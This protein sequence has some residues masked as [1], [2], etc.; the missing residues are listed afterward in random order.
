MIR[1][2]LIFLIGFNLIACSS[3]S[4]TKENDIKS[5]LHGVWAEYYTPEGEIISYVTYIP[6]GRFHGFGYYDENKTEYWFAHGLWEMRGNQSCI[7]FQFD[8]YGMMDPNEEFC[9]EVLS[10]TEGTFIYKDNVDGKKEILKRVSTGY[11]TQSKYE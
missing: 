7:K 8:T 3:S 10:V 11:L 6:E 9:V 5:L 4:G 2:I 1:I